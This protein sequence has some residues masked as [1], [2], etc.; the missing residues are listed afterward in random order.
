MKRVRSGCVRAAV[1]GAVFVC[2]T[3]AVHAGGYRFTDLG[4]LGG[5]SSRAYAINDAGQVVGSSDV[6]DGSA[7][8]A[9][10]WRG[11]TTTDLGTLGGTN[12]RAYG[13]NRAGEIV[14]ASDVAGDL[15]TH[16]VLWRGASPSDLGTLGGASSFAYGISNTGRIVGGSTVAGAPG[17]HATLWSGGARTDLGGVPGSSGSY[18]NGINDRGVVVGGSVIAGHAPFANRATTWSAAGP[19][20]LVGLGGES[21][22]MGVN[23]AGLTVGFGYL[24]NNLNARALLW[25][26]N[27]MTPL[28]NLAGNSSFAAAINNEGLV[29]GWS[30]TVDPSVGQ[31]AV[32]WNGTT[33]TDLN[34]YID[35]LAASEGW[36]LADARG[37]ND[38]GWIVGTARN[39]LT[40]EAHAYLLSVSSVPEP[41]SWAMLLLGLVVLA[42]ARHRGQPFTQISGS[43]RATLRVRPAISAASTTARMFL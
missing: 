15:G 42:M 38:Q 20:A 14:G 16:A 5:G 23:D 28:D 22:A 10:L 27:S 13:I 19:A 21:V 41:G 37:I 35:P 32:L 2:T 43:S 29:V 25:N 17:V 40:G 30:F 1:C 7:V 36:Y 39:D 6:A 8:H 11:S 26:G 4:T 31:H 33:V 12:S 18:L 9:T 24:P 3:G 34:R